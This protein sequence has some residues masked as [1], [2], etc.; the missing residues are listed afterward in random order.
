[1]RRITYSLFG[2]LILA[3]SGLGAL[4]L[5]GLGGERL[6]E[7]DKYPSFIIESF[8]TI[9]ENYW[10]QLENEALAELFRLSGERVSGGVSFSFATTTPQ[11]VART[12]HKYVENLKSE[13]EKKEFVTLLVHTVLQNLKPQGRSALYTKK[14]ETALRETVANINNDK[15]LYT[16]LGLAEGA[17]EESVTDAFTKKK[18]VLEQGEQTTETKKELEELV[19]AKEVLTDRETKI[20][21]DEQKIEPTVFAKPLTPEIAYIHIERFSPTTFNDFIRVSDDLDDENLNTLILDLRGN[22]G[23]AIDLLQWFLGPFIGKDQYAYEFFHQGEYTPFKTQ[24]GWLP[25]LVKYKRVIV[26]IDDKV[27]SSGEVMA[28]TLQKYN[29]GV[30]VGVKTRGWGTVENTYPL[31]TTLDDTEKFSLFLVNNITLRS[32]GQ[33]IEGRGVDPTIDI[34]DPDWKEKLN[35]YFNDN[36][37]IETVA[38]LVEK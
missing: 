2:I 8:K 12:L 27:Q 32:D 10:E 38:K 23:G 19:Y 20:L 35:V 22:I 33:P 18:E 34:H 37:L 25:S 24:V 13:Q 5:I 29:V 28:A 4:S 15:S 1:M 30:L 26:L 9:Q 6:L 14:Q 36:E 21:Y 7:K 11:E 31:E 17:S 3:V 16:T